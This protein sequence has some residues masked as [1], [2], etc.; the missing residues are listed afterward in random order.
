MKHTL[1]KIFDKV[2]VINLKSR[3]DRYVNM[4]QKLSKLGIEFEF[5]E[6]VNGYTEENVK[7]FEEYQS[8]PLDDPRSHQFDKRDKAKKMFGPG[9]IGYSKSYKNILLNAKAHG[10]KKIF[11]FD[12]DVLFHNDFD[13]EV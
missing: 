1:N 8:Y 5:V 7:L 10:Y 13:V 2:Y 12:D 11:C 6:A 4:T 9:A 3:R